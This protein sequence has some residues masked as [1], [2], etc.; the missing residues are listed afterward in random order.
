M[1][2]VRRGSREVH[3][4]HWP[5]SLS[6]WRGMRA[7]KS[8]LFLERDVVEPMVFYKGAAFLDSKAMLNSVKDQGTC[9]L[10]T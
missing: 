3:S 6:T 8:C 1:L 9:S 7:S 4:K 10:E 5:I 2:S